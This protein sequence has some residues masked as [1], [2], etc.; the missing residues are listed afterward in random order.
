M[1]LLYRPSNSELRMQ[2]YFQ[3]LERHLCIRYDLCVDTV[4][5]SSHYK[6]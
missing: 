1:R 5:V 4:P 2:N 3:G 6:M